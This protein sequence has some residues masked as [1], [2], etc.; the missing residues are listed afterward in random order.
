MMTTAAM[1]AWIMRIS[2]RAS[3]VLLRL[4]LKHLDRRR[5]WLFFSYPAIRVKGPK[6][7]FNKRETILSAPLLTRERLSCQ[8]GWAQSVE[9]LGCL[10]TSAQVSIGRFVGGLSR[11][12]RQG[13]SVKH[14]GFQGRPALPSLHVVAQPFVAPQAG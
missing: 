4:F 8:Q 11:G 7:L 2:R 9:H 5:A 3:M 12:S 10:S 14:V 6:D 13:K 1:Q